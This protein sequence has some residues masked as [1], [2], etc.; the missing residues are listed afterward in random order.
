MTTATRIAAAA[1]SPDTAHTVFRTVLDAL[2]RPGT[3]VELPEAAL[4]APLLAVSA[5]ADHGAGIH[6]LGADAA[7]WT[8]ALRVTTGAPE[9]AL[10]TARLVGALR[11][12]SGA[13]LTT[14]SR[15]SAAAP[16]RGAL[17]AVPV[18]ALDGGVPLR[19]SG[20]GIDGVAELAPL[21]LPGDFLA[22]RAE[23]VAGFPA[24]V[25]LLLVTA[26]GRMAGL[27]RTTVL[28]APGPHADAAV[29]GRGFPARAQ[30]D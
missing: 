11:P 20:P 21:G 19:L 13:E 14:L 8:D 30:E 16:E 26:D 18:A 23:A 10:G 12:L 24:G 3:V 5:L 9:A 6:I 17:A 28:S 15:G 7:A 2:A 4:P 25:D 29:D 1:L 27:P 22:A